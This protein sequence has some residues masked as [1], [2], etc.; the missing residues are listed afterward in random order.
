MGTPSPEIYESA[1]AEAHRKI[2]HSRLML[3]HADTKAS[4]L[5]AGT[6]P[7]TALLLAAPSLTDP[8]GGTSAIAWSGA[9]FLLSGIGFLGAVVWPRLSG[10]SGIR[11]TA[12]RSPE[13]VMAFLLETA[14]DLNRRLLAAS[15]EETLL[16]T[17]ALDKFRRLRAA[18]TCFAIAAVL[19]L[20]TAVALV[21]SG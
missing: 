3:A 1:I 7:L 20:A 19:M 14:S 13:Q 11:A 16:A 4:L 8:S 10:N 5:A 17:L 18:M 6:I 9:A 15:E 21:V 2:E 12:H